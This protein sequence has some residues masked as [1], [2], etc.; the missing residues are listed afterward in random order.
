MPRHLP[1]LSSRKQP[2]HHPD[3]SRAT[4]YTF[5]TSGGSGVEQSVKDLQGL[6]PDVNLVSGKR[7]NNASQE[8]IKNCL[9]SLN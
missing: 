1:G 4:V 2:P 8:D 9:D 5:C 3:L 6:Y 7:L